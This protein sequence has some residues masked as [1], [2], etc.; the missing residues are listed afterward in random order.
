MP[1]MFYE[2]AMVHGGLERAAMPKYPP[3]K[4]KIAQNPVG[5]DAVEVTD[6]SSTKTGG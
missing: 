5:N 1:E 4:V 3:K 2:S 6:A